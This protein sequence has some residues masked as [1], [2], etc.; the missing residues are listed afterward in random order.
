MMNIFNKRL[1]REKLLIKKLA[2][3][4][5]NVNRIVLWGFTSSR[6]SHYYIHLGY[7]NFFKENFGV[8]I[9]WLENIA[10]NN[11]LIEPQDLIMIPDVHLNNGV[12]EKLKINKPRLDCYYIYHNSI[13]LQE[14]WKDKSI[15]YIKLYEYRNDYKKKLTEKGVSL[16]EIR[17]FVYTSDK[18]RS[19]LQPWGY[20]I[21]PSKMLSPNSNISDQINFVGTVWGDDKGEVNGNKL[22]IANL[23]KNLASKNIV[24]NTHS[25]LT[26]SEEIELLRKSVVST[27][28][29][30]IGHNQSSY[31]QCRIF[32]S[33][34]YGVLT[35]TDTMAFKE[36]L[37][38]SFV[39]FNSWEEG[40]EKVLNLSS[41]KKLE[42]IQKQQKSIADYSYLNH[43]VNIFNLF[44]KIHPE[45]FSKQSK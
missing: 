20:P 19:I 37:K 3:Q 13:S 43:W 32:K 27:A 6:H 4:L 16:K 39:D 18:D 40:I 17:P 41:K 2:N 45:S 34:T 42:L 33:I 5:K 12:Y 24:L 38:D 14:E 28:I 44:E 31:L 30:A 26:E 10:K 21:L 15:K 35:L 25:K 22:K 8:E 23:K 11:D 36:I 29:G 1:N 9:I 7:Y